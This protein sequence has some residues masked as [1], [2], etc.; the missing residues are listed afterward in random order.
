MHHDHVSVAEL[1]HRSFQGRTLPDHREQLLA[2]ESVCTQ[3]VS[4]CRGS[5]RQF[6]HTFCFEHQE[7]RVPRGDLKRKVG[8]CLAHDLRMTLSDA[9]YSSVAGARESPSRP[10]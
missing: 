2:L 6:G 7:P 8:V 1:L 9:S 3:Q 5:S 4:T 10:G